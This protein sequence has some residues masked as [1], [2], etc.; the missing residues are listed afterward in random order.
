[1]SIKKL[2][3]KVAVGAAV[4]ALVIAG[5]T[6]VV[7]QHPGG[8]GSDQVLGGNTA[9]LENTALELPNISGSLDM[10]F[11]VDRGAYLY[12]QTPMGADADSTIDK[13]SRIDS[14][15]TYSGVTGNVGRVW[16]ET[17]FENWDVVASLHNNGRL[18]RVLSDEEK[19]PKD[20]VSCHQTGGPFS[21]EVCVDTIMY[22]SGAPL[23]GRG[24]S[25]TAGAFDTCTL[26][27]A[28][29]IIHWPGN[30]NNVDSSNVEVDDTL[31][32][33]A[34]GKASFAVSI[35]KQLYRKGGY[36][37]GAG[38]DSLSAFPGVKF[39]TTADSAMGRGFPLIEGDGQKVN[40]AGNIFGAQNKNYGSVLFF[41]NARIKQLDGDWKIAGNKNG[42]YRE[43]IEFQF[44][45]LY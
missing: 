11:T 28:V 20:T 30:A 17:N 5:A 19:V 3:G 40:L 4:G 14:V 29:G 43:T 15:R 13:L 41:I 21:H 8:A 1:M 23:R 33:N 22:N 39:A 37:G 32:F 34:Q 2:L 35:G 12:A 36:L 16:V 6:M 25:T 44:F 42:V 18:F 45:G 10:E 31:R 38:S 24:P 26:D 7:A 9:N 27:M